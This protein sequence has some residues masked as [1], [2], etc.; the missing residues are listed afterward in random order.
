[1][2]NI[3]L[4]TLL[5]NYRFAEEMKSKDKSC[6]SAISVI[7]VLASLVNEA[8][9]L[10]LYNFFFFTLAYKTNFT[11]VCVCS[12]LKYFWGK[13]SFFLRKMH[14]DVSFIIPVFNVGCKP[15]NS[16]HFPK[17]ELY[18]LKSLAIGHNDFLIIKKMEKCVLRGR[19]NN[20]F[21]ERLLI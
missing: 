11:C 21:G 14:S 17:F 20:G 12:V 9:E 7:Y 10:Q 3:S 2:M 13:K 8:S 16:L 18:C 15:L 5:I 19:G 4:E 1:M 6:L